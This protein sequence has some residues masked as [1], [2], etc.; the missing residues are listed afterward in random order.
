MLLVIN[1][2]R[3]KLE[4]TKEQPS[5]RLNLPSRQKH[6]NPLNLYVVSNQHFPKTNECQKK[7]YLA[8]SAQTLRERISELDHS[9]AL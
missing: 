8:V 4:C 3:E 6:H 7:K 9:V 1:G 2:G 5:V